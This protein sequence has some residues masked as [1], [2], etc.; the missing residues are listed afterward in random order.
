LK[1]EL[2]GSELVP[3]WHRRQMSLPREMFW[4]L[5]NNNIKRTMDTENRYSRLVEDGFFILVLKCHRQIVRVQPINRL[6]QGFS[7]RNRPK[8]IRKFTRPPISA[9][10]RKVQFCTC[11]SQR[12]HVRG[13]TRF[14]SRSKRRLPRLRFFVVTPGK[15]RERTSIRPRPLPSESFRN[16]H[17]SIVL[18]FDA[19]LSRY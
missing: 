18:R 10:Q 5:I 8:T 12:I 17:S 11:H 3:L 19:I 13:G 9:D 6:K 4:I 2:V 16:Y 15:S 7:N 1:P 14:E